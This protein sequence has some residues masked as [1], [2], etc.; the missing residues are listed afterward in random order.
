M[1]QAAFTCQAC[2]YTQASEAQYIGRSFACPKCKQVA[3]VVA[4]APA[5]PKAPAAKTLPPPAPVVAPAATPAAAQSPAVG[6][7]S[8][9]AAPQYV[10]S[11]VTPPLG[12]PAAASAQPQAA[13]SQTAQGGMSDQMKI[14]RVQ[15]QSKSMVLGLVLTFFL[16]GFGIFYVSII[17]GVICAILELALWVVVFMSMGLLSF[18]AWVFHLIMMLYVAVAISSHN[19]KLINLLN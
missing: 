10:A 14:A 4:V 9:A 12:S 5:A 1:S 2:G 16:G 13:P 7:S 19:K 15:M 17:G 6:S 11:P 18:L 3:Q 8:A